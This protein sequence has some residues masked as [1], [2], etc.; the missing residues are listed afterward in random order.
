M[1]KLVIE[2][3]DIHPMYAIRLVEK[4]LDMTDRDEF[5][6]PNVPVVKEVESK[7]LDNCETSYIVK[8]ENQSDGTRKYETLHFSVK[9]GTS[10]SELQIAEIKELIKSNDNLDMHIRDLLC[11]VISTC[12]PSI[13]SGMA[14]GI[15]TKI[16]SNVFGTK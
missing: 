16:M 11:R 3:N 9:K 15:T 4:F 5:I 8:C 14:E 13:N 1:N 7:S 12:Y 10:K 2:S 6:N